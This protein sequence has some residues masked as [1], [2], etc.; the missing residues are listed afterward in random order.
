[1]IPFARHSK[2]ATAGSVG[3]YGIQ[4]SEE[5]LPDNLQQYGGVITNRTR[6]N[7]KERSR[8]G[9]RAISG[10]GTDSDDENLFQTM[11]ESKFDGTGRRRV[12]SMVESLSSP[13]SDI[14]GTIFSSSNRYE[15]QS[16]GGSKTVTD[17]DD[18]M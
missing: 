11:G 14:S 8:S 1:M 12:H 7:S 4:R 3:Y 5:I 2:L 17:S 16:S 15:S 6:S 10:R 13:M 18:E 9:S